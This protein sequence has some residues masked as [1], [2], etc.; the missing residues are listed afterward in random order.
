VLRHPL[1]RIV[2]LAL[3]VLTLFYWAHRFRYTLYDG[4][5]LKGQSAS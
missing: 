3:C 2:L 4:L 5:Q 1:T